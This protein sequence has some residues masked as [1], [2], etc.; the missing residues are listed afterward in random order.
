MSHKARR[1]IFL[2]A[3]DAHAD[4]LFAFCLKH[5]H[6]RDVALDVLQIT[7]M[8]TWEYLE[9]GHSIGHARGFLFRVARNAIID[10]SRKPNLVS[11]DLLNEQGNLQPE[12][13]SALSK[14][15]NSLEKEHIQSLVD[16][17]PNK[18][19]QEVLQRRFLQQQS[20]DEIAKAL[21]LTK[22]AA[23]VRVNR[24]VSYFKAYIKRHYG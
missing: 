3:Y 24:S 23:S 1:K 19:H 4:E 22:N 7:F 15:E 8:R 6:D 17:L 12:D 5:T 21:S 2:Q 20:M 18:K 11:L 10:W 9:R 13:E 16:Q 14:I